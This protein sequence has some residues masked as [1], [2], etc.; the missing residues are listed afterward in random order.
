MTPFGVVLLAAGESRRMG[1]P[2]QLLPYRGM[3]LVEHATRTALASGAAEIVVVLGAH[4]DEIRATLAALPVIVVQNPEWQT[5]MGS[6]IAH[7]VAVLRPEI[8]SAVI[9]LADQPKITSEHLHALAAYADPVAASLYDGE[10][11]APCAFARSEFPRLLTLQGDQGARRILRGGEV[12]VQ[13]VLFEPGL[14]DLDT[15]EA[16][17]SFINEEAT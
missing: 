14:L 13:P 4:A 8:E 17:A 6:S 9:A 5:G 10:L 16:Y 1:K 11:G 2:K 3:T 15:P 7:G 12:R